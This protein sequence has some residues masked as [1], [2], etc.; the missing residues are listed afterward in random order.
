[1][2]FNVQTFLHKKVI[3]GSSGPP[4]REGGTEKALLLDITFV[5][6]NRFA[7]SW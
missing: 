2:C 7:E 1:M 6:L 5:E 3:T 4:V